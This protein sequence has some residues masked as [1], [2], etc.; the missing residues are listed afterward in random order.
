MFTREQL[1]RSAEQSRADGC[2]DTKD[3]GSDAGSDQSIDDYPLGVFGTVIIDCPRPVQLHTGSKARREAKQRSAAVLER[4]RTLRDV[5]QRHEGVL[6]RRWSNK[7]KGQKLNILLKAWPGMA[8]THRPD[9]D[10]YR[11]ESPEQRAVGTAFKEAYLWPY[12]NQED[13]SKNGALQLFL[14]ARG[15]HP[16][17][18]F[19]AADM[20]AAAFG[21]LVSDALIPKFLVGYTMILSGVT[22]SNIDD[23]GKIVGWHTHPGAAHLY[24]TEHEFEPGEGLLVPEIQE[25][26]YSFLVD[27]CKEI[28]HDYPA[29]SWTS[30]AFPI[31]PEPKMKS[32]AELTGF[33]S[34]AVMAAEAPYRVPAQLDLGKI[35]SLLTARTA[36]AEDRLWALR[37]DPLFL[38]DQILEAKDHLPHQLENASA[39]PLP[40]AILWLLATTFVIREAFVQLE[41]FS[42]L[43]QQAEWLQALQIRYA[44]VISPKEDL[45]DEYH[46]AI[47]SF[48]LCLESSAGGRLENL[49]IAAAASIPLRRFFVD[50]AP[51]QMMQ[52]SP[53][54]VM[55]RLKPEALRTRAEHSLVWLLGFLADNS[56][57]LIMTATGVDELQRLV[58][59]DPEVSRLLTPFSA[60]LF[61]DV[62]ILAQC[63][64]QINLYHPWARRF[65]RRLDEDLA[66]VEEL[67]S[68]VDAK[69]KSSLDFLAEL[70]VQNFTAAAKV[71]APFERRFPYPIEKRRTK[72]NVAALREAERNLDA[73]W[74]C[75]DRIIQK[76][77]GNLDGTA[78]RRLL[79]QTALSSARP[80]GLNQHPAD[81]QRS[82]QP[83][84]PKT[85]FTSRSRPSTSASN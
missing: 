19:A 60:T 17:S 20:D 2:D 81:E 34:L 35:I 32:G 38:R 84:T 76:K 79:S 3:G 78:T 74:D 36:A 59:A 54:K 37:E 49:Q 28:L 83:R 57:D 77:A 48:W 65:P 27:C 6:H 25:R 85:W 23:Y 15:R 43:R 29:D 52:R 33:E 72:E 11:K 14:N 31:Q 4:W 47:L 62:S 8:L 80:N 63:L 12:I 1:M 82:L 64:R 40:E 7:S 5:I 58:E 68:A 30:D 45:P 53:G 70:H 66:K 50:A 44:S 16:P 67:K 13:L 69:S 51:L 42:D 39:E 18:A 26:L 9:L 61:G 75:I 21:L 22:E 73:F 56:H 10:A 55:L 41:L 71:A 24:A 46:D